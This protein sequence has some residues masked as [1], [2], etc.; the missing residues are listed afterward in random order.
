MTGVPCAPFCALFS[1]PFTAVINTHS[2]VLG[3][4]DLSAAHL[5]LST[6]ELF[7]HCHMSHQLSWPHCH[8][9]KSGCHV[10]QP[11]ARWGENQVDGSHMG[12]PR[13]PR[14]TKYQCP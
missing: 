13:A 5:S 9:H 8:T 10:E 4:L 14:G 6:L 7:C 2:W 1:L 11:L 3:A 12:H